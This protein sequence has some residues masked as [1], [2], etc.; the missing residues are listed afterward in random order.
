MPLADG[1]APAVGAGHE[2]DSLPD[3]RG[4]ERQIPD[5]GN[6][7]AGDVGQARQF[8]AEGDARG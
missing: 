6:S 5:L 4:E 2:E 7:S 8:G 3:V 1:S